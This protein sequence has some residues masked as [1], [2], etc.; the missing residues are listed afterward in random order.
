MNSNTVSVV[1]PT[2]NGEHFIGECL[3]SISVQ[4]VPH[5]VIIV[6]D[7]ST[8]RTV[9]IAREKGAA[10]IVNEVHKGQV[11]GK[12]TGIKNMNG[13]YFLTIDQDDRLK[14]DALSDLINEMEDNSAQIVMSKLEDFADT[15][16]DVPFC[17]QEPFR[18]ILTGAALFRKEVFDTIGLFDESIITGDVIDLADRCGKNGVIIY[19][20]DI[21]TCER[22]IHSS[23]YGRTN[24]KDE[25]KDYAKLLRKQFLEKIN[26]GRS[27]TD[28]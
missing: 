3:D 9:E 26:N 7:M 21:I 1:I 28:R 27:E 10:V 2:Y 16:S 17:H 15:E 6:D 5:E 14:P 20:S 13:A 25:Y 8:D 24:Q 18:G 19:K 23:N 12:N 4:K 22:R 11:A